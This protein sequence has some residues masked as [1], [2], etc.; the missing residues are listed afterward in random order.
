MLKKKIKLIPFDPARYL[1]TE[2]QIGHFLELSC[3]G[4]N[5]AHIARALGVAAKARGMSKLSK[6]TGLTRTT[7]YNILSEKGNPELKTLAK[8]LDA[9]GLRLSI[10]KAE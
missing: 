9:L 6:K 10:V 4:N 5:P 8:I 1:K 3:V 2:E 7:L